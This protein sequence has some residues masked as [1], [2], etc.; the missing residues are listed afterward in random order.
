M[1]R[2]DPAL[3]NEIR[4]AAKELTSRNL[5]HFLDWNATVIPPS[6]QMPHVPVC[7]AQ[8][9]VDSVK[10]DPKISMLSWKLREMR[11]N[12]VDRKDHKR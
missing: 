2:Q 1:P 9:C 7:R 10:Y 5:F 11:G 12:Y 8:G 4:R 6:R 3:R